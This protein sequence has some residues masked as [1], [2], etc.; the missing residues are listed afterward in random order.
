MNLGRYH[1][2]KATAVYE[3]VDARNVYYELI[4]AYGKVS[5]RLQVVDMPCYRDCG[6][7]RVD[8][9]D[10]CCLCIW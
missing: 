1:H 3:M 7:G 9:Y 4:C 8:I 6:P 2:S 5:V 10:V